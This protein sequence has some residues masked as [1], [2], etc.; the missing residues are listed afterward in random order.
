MT[1]TI[2]R[3]LHAGFLFEDK[4]TKIIFDPIFENPFSRN[5]FAFPEVTFNHEKI[6]NLKIDAVFISHYHDDHLS[7][8]SLNSLSK[9]TPIYI[10]C[11]FPE[12]IE[13][14]KS[15]GFLNVKP[16]ILRQPIQIG[17]MTI[18]PLPALD[19]EVDCIFHIK[20]YDYNILNVVDSWID[21]EVFEE[22][23]LTKWDLILW[24]FQTMR[25]LEALS[26]LRA[27]ASD[28]KIPIELI[29]Q[30]QRLG[31]KKLVPSSCQFKFEKWSWLNQFYFPISYSKFSEQ[32]LQ[33]LPL[34]KVLRMDPSVSVVLSND[35]LA[36]GENLDWVK[37]ETTE[38]VDYTYEVNS[39]VPS[40][41][42]VAKNFESLSSQAC[43]FVKN[44]CL[45]GLSK[46]SLSL[47]DLEESY[48]NKKRVWQLNTYNN[49]GE[50]IEYFYS[51]QGTKIDL[52][53]KRPLQKVE[54]L[55][56]ISEAR[57]NSALT[58]GESLSSLYIRINDICFDAQTEV[59]IQS[60]DLFHDP[61]IRCLYE[62]KVGLYQK[63][64]LKKISAEF[65]I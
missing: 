2:S 55:T 34:T 23:L 12:L 26:P 56:E 39:K 1:L 31:P 7:L 14:V 22:L 63:A 8:E 36:R 50:V 6:K 10:F 30:L 15:L 29:R 11:I 51:V 37:C 16:I 35:S 27:E 62:G 25:E 64:Q 60:A 47:V 53:K 4:F 58:A 54:W 28:C 24:P 46:A 41:A 57:L 13:L 18:I 38:I 44:Y 19:A 45:Q 17:E 20:A 61:L 42:E 3:I 33:I 48:F 49:L 40:T 32:I 9:T 21:P 5:C 59:E 52:L 65:S 43:E